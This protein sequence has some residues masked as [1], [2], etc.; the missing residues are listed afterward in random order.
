[1]TLRALLV[2]LLATPAVHAQLF[3]TGDAGRTAPHWRVAVDGGLSGALTA[4]G[5]AS[6]ERTV[7]GPVS[8]GGRVM[9]YSSSGFQDDGGG[10]V[11]TAAEAFAAAGLRRRAADLHVFAG[12]G[13]S[14][15]RTYTNGFGGLGRSQ[16]RALRPHAVAGVGLD[17]YPLPG[18]GVGATV[19]ATASDTAVTLATV[20]LG[21]RVRLAR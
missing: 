19:R 12:A 20:A 3:P 21:L 14:A 6:A 5:S 15:V 1:M 18:V 11:G 9:L 10:I 7:S 17:L 13:A 16:A 4:V 2:L 8:A